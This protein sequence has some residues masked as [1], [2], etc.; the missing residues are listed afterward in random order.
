MKVPARVTAGRR[1]ASALSSVL[2]CLLLVGVGSSTLLRHVIQVMLIGLVLVAMSRGNRV[3]PYLALPIFTIWPLLMALIW[4]YLVGRYR[5]V[6]QRIVLAGRGRADRS[7]RS[8]VGP[9]NCRVPGLVHV[10]GD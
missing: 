9:W 10:L 4:L 3:G 1:W 2:V 7:D 8:A 6:L 5:D